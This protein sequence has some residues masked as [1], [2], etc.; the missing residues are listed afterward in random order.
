[1]STDAIE[2]ENQYYPKNP[3]LTASAVLLA[4]FIFVL[5]GTIANVALPH[6]AGSFSVTRDESIWILT[7]YLIASGIVIPAVDWFS[8][9]FGRKNF[10]IISIL[11]FTVA[12]LLCGLANSLLTMVLAR[13]LQGFGGGGIVPI[14]QAIMLESFPKRERPKAMAVFGMG[15]IIAPIIGPVLGGWITDNWTWP[16]IYFINVPFGCIAALMCKKILVDPPYAKRQKGVK[17]DALG[18]FLLVVWITCLQIVLD[19]GQQYNWFDTPWIC[20][21]TGICIFS[22]VLFYV[23]ELEYKYPLIDI[24]VFKD[25]NFLIGTFVC[26]FLNIML[27]STLLLVP[28]FVQSLLGYSPSMSGFAMFPRAVTCLI[29]LLV[30][31]EIS[32]FFESR[33]LATIGLLIMGFAV[34]QLSN[35]NTTASIETVIWPNILLCIGVPTAFIPITALAFQTL[36]PKRTADA[37]ALHAMFKNVI[38]AVATSVSATFIARVSQV[39]QTYLVHNLSGENPLYYHKLM[40][41]QAKFSALF[42]HYT[43]ARKAAGSLYNQMLAQARLCSFYDAFL[44]LALLCVMVIPFVLIL[45]NKTKQQKSA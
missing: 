32:R 36:E 19:K 31:G 3:W 2:E 16:W 34:F 14:S 24:R 18:F 11:L 1:M 7:S 26:S 41:A 35:L 25:K 42:N 40:A 6:M 9:V 30:V 22:F 8:K 27:Y 39:H 43:A 45:K 15:I 28:M 21:L 37:A 13:V 44:V 5:D 10:F 20:W 29:G 23:W 12:S 33:L 38:T 4:V 17:I